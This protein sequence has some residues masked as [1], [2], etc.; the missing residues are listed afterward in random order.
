MT[1]AQNPKD[2][3]NDDLL[4]EDMPALIALAQKSFTIAARAAVAENDRLGIPTHGSIDGKLVVRQP[5][6][7]IPNSP[8]S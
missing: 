6:E 2:L 4:F 8:P 3:S 7:A 1:D 5:P